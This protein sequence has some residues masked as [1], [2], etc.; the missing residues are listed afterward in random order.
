MATITCHTQID[1]VAATNAEYT[2][3]I[4]YLNAL[5]SPQ[6]ASRTEN[7]SKRTVSLDA[8]DV[9]LNRTVW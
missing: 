8:A 6:F 9:V 4:A 1:I 3:I 5:T 7:A 2:Q